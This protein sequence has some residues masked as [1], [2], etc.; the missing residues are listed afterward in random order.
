MRRTRRS[1]AGRRA[2]RAPGPLK[3]V[4]GWAY[5]RLDTVRQPGS[6]SL[7]DHDRWEVRVRRRDRGHDRGIDHRQSIDAM[8]PTTR[9][10]DVATT[11]IMAHPTRSNRVMV[12]RDARANR[13]PQR[14]VGVSDIRGRRQ[15]A[16]SKA[17]QWLRA[18]ETSGQAH[19]FEHA[20]HVVRVAEVG[21]I[22]TRR[23]G[24]ISGAQI[25]AAARARLENGDHHAKRC[26]AGVLTDL[27]HG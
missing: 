9:V 13:S 3:R 12:R 25:Q 4:V 18:R 6:T 23:L 8:D 5:W 2:S 24:R 1:A 22:D 7:R 19:Y 11:W 15:R 26:F 16:S 10:H 27:R 17:D 14:A 21:G 20:R